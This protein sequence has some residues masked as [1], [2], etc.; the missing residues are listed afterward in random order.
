MKNIAYPFAIDDYRGA[1]AESADHTE[2]VKQMITQVLFTA[3][4]ERMNRPE[5]GCGLRRMIFAPNSDVTASLLQITIYEALENW[6]G[7]LIS[8]D[9]VEVEAREEILEVQIVYMLKTIRQRQYL[10]LEVTL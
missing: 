8:V 9:Q 10:N 1:F 5:F 4:G 7:S 2:H 6:L 3:P